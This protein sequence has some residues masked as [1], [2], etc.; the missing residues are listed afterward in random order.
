MGWWSEVMRSRAR[1]WAYLHI[2]EPGAEPSVD[3]ETSYVSVFLTSAHIVDRRRGFRAYYGAVNSLVR[4]A[5]R[6][7]DEAEFAAV[8]TPASLREAGGDNLDR[9]LQVNHRLLGPVPFVGG[10][11]GIEVGLFSVPAG[12][13]ALPY[14]TL[15]ETLSRQATVA[16][17]ATA[18]PFVGPIVEGV[19]LLAGA[20][21]SPE[22]EIGFSTMWQPLR[23]GWVIAIAEE[24]GGREYT[25]DAVDGRLLDAAGQPVTDRAYL[26]LRV[27]AEP[28][29][30]D[31]AR[32]PEIAELYGQLRAEFR[33]GHRNSLSEAMIAFKRVTL[34][35][36]DLLF[37][38]ALRVVE[39]VEIRFRALGGRAGGSR[40]SAERGTNLP[41]LEELDPFRR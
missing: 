13:L 23:P 33:R 12:N 15:L 32:I 36:D 8:V 5:T 26:V 20:G 4:L 3:P 30:D 11:V 24:R 39:A 28:R 9:F 10:D 34:T 38:D 18:K 22:L 17:V 40:G 19:N 7:G 29:R 21:E 35:C 1:Q 31:W 41:S 37:D 6:S 16:F 2:P 14:I 25:V 27:T